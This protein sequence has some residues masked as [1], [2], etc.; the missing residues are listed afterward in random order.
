MSAFADLAGA[1]RDA[2]PEVAVVLGS[3]LG[4]LADRVTKE[5][6]A[7][8]TDVPGLPAAA[9]VGHRGAFSVGRWAGRRVLLIEGR[10]HFYEGHPWEVVTLPV[11]TAARLGAR[12]VVLT[13]AA[14]GIADAL[15]PGCLMALAAQMEWNHPHVWRQPAPPSPYSPRLLAAL[16][17]AA[18]ASGMALAEGTYAAVTGPCY[19][20]PAEVRAL[21]AHGADAV[22]M[23]STREALA[24][25]A[26]GL[27]VAGVSLITNRAAGLSAMPPDHTEVLTVARATAA[28]LADLLERFLT[29]LPPGG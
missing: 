29:E 12:I 27:E 20:T 15:G 1:C 26:A 24:A 13:N 3:G 19:E 8:F 2:P 21:R 22:G 9:V 5:V 10:L 11:R 17:R 14:G 23:S 4:P 18:T 6:S 25:V 16:R 28:W 7:P